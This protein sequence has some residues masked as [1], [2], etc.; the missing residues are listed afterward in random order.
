L[1]EFFGLNRRRVSILMNLN[2]KG[3]RRNILKQYGTWELLA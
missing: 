3:C 1:G 2:L